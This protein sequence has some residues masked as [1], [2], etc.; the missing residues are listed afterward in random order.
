MPVKRIL[1]Q[2]GHAPPREPGF[3]SGTGTTREIELALGIQASLVDLFTKDARFQPVP[4]PG[5]IP[6]GVKVDAALFLHGDGSA[7]QS[8]SG[9]CFGYPRHNV[10]ERLATLL[11]EE[12]DKI[13]GH[14][15][16]RLDNY[17]SGLRYYYGYSRVATAG[18]EV[19]VEH[20]FLTN[21]GERL[22]LFANMSNLAKA[23]YIAVCR[24]FG[25]VP[26]SG[27]AQNLKRRR[28]TRTWILAQ[29]KLGRSWAWIKKQ[30]NWREYVR[31]GGK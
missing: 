29:R 9:Y 27:D 2:A 20:G 24:Y 7:N 1:I 13:P 19:L 4:V 16:H 26:F 5:D 11:R 6:D 14:P 28:A 8:A 12:I 18:P 17:T 10:N 3:E 21:P 30:P 22:W 31:R 25:L 15:P 23:E